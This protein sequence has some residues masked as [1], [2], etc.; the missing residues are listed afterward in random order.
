M[1]TTWQSSLTQ[2]GRLDSIV[3]DERSGIEHSPLP[4]YTEHIVNLITISVHISP[5]H[6]SRCW[7]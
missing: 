7:E 4:P 3:A 6:S 2:S 5:I 1:Q